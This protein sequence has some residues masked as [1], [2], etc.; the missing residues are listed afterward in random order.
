MT[1]EEQFIAELELFRTEAAGTTQSLLAPMRSAAVSTANT[2]RSQSTSDMR[3]E[4]Q[5][6]PSPML[7]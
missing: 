5:L 3:T 4:I 6:R 7:T 2:R 1:A